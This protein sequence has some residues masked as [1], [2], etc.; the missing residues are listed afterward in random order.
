MILIIHNIKVIWSSN[1]IAP[2]AYKHYRLNKNISSVLQFFFMSQLKPFA[3]NKFDLPSF[4][5]FL[6]SNLILHHFFDRFRIQ[7]RTNCSFTCFT[8]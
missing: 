7:M 2:D 1:S 6:R 5:S 3:N 8:L 4:L